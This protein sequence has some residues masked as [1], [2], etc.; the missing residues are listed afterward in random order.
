M[1]TAILSGQHAMMTKFGDFTEAHEAVYDLRSATDALLEAQAEARQV[2]IDQKH[3]HELVRLQDELRDEAAKT[4]QAEREVAAL[5]AKLDAAEQ[6]AKS[7]ELED[8]WRALIRADVAAAT[9]ALAKITS[10][11]EHAREELNQMREQLAKQN[12]AHQAAIDALKQ[13]VGSL[14][15]TAADDQRDA[16]AKLAEERHKE[17]VENQASAEAFRN[18]LLERLDGLGHTFEREL[19]KK[20]GE[21]ELE[22]ESLARERIAA[23]EKE[24]H[25]LRAE[26]SFTYLSLADISSPKLRPTAPTCV[27][28]SPKRSPMSASSRRRRFAWL[29]PRPTPSA[30]WSCSSRPRRRAR[31]TSRPRCSARK[32][33]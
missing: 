9:A 15:V 27:S 8:V 28:S 23:L 3:G 4:A 12:T 7:K 2:K 14:Q 13:E 25:D 11:E 26:V 10:S 30:R 29:T 33:M 18:K 32:P 17:L 31:P 21:A 24:V 20:R 5:K 16:A 6:A 1:L 22:R 19:E